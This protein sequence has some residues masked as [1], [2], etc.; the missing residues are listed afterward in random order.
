MIGD[1]QVEVSESA[2]VLQVAI[3]N[4]SDTLVFPW[5]LWER[6]VQ[7]ASYEMV[8]WALQNPEKYRNLNRQM[9]R[10]DAGARLAV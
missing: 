9:E 5:P 2:D 10:L 3:S 6:L 8:S 1:T 4:G 7:Y